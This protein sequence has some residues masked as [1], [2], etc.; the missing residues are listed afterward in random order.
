MLIATSPKVIFQGFQLI[1][2]E[3]LQNL[4]IALPPPN[5]SDVVLDAKQKKKKR[6][7]QLR[8]DVESRSTA[9]EKIEPQ[10]EQRYFFGCAFDAN[11]I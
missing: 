8:L 11:F 7:T 9:Q 6:L 3:L 10:T 2:V 4:G 1:D 5:L